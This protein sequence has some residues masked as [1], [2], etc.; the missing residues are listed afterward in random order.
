MNQHNVSSVTLEQEPHKIRRDIN[1]DNVSLKLRFLQNITLN[2][3]RG[4]L[5]IALYVGADVRRAGVN[6]ICTWC[7][8]QEIESLERTPQG[9]ES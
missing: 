1:I 6:V 9:T 8:G 2:N 7:W 5:P 3:S 4:S